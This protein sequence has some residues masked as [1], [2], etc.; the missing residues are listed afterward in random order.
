[1]LS[2][3]RFLCLTITKLILGESSRKEEKKMIKKVKIGFIGCGGLETLE[4]EDSI[5]I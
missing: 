4:Q 3:R 1:M 5:Q 2:T